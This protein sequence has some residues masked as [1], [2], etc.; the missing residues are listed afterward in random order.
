MAGHL[1]RRLHQHSTQ[2]FQAHVQAQ[3]LDLTSV[4]YAALDAISETPGIDQAGLAESIGYDR[5]TIGGV[6]ERLETKGFVLREISPR[7]RRA[8]QLRLTDHGATLLDRV[9]PVVIAAQI[10]ILADLLPEE[11]QI[12]LSLAQKALGLTAPEG[13]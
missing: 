12:F 6:I 2:V 10:D 5:A 13:G 3:G 9:R 7:D 8:R 11:R 4:Q 1:I